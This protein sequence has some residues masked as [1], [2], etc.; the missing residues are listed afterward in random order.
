MSVLIRV[1]FLLTVFFFLNNCSSN[2]R[3]ID[4]TVWDDIIDI[5]EEIG[6]GKSL[7]EALGSVK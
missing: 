5:S 2:G 1:F 4:P 3:P 6:K 7:T